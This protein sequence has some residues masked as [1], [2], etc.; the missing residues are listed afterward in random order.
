LNR[1]LLYRNIFIVTFLLVNLKL[2]AQSY[3][4]TY[5]AANSLSNIQVGKYP[6]QEVDIRFLAEHTGYVERIRLFIAR[7]PGYSDGT[8]GQ[9]KISLETDD[10]TILHRPSGNILASYLDLN[11]LINGTHNVVYTFNNPAKLTAGKLYHIHF[12]NPDSNPMNNWVSINFIYSTSGTFDRMPVTKILN[13]AV[14]RKEGL[15]PFKD[16]TDYT[17]LY[18]LFYSDSTQ[19]GQ[20]YHFAGVQTPNDISGNDF[21]VRSN[22]TVSGGDKI[23]TKVWARIKKVSGNEDLIMRLEETDGSLI[24]EVVVPNSEISS[25]M[26]WIS[27][28][29]ISNHK[30]LNGSN[31][32]LTLYTGNSTTYQTFWM[33]NGGLDWVIMFP[34]G[35][36]QYTTTG[37]TKWS[38][39]IWYDAQIFF[40][41]NNETSVPKY[42]NSV[43][44]DANPSQVKITY[45]MTLAEPVPPSTAFTVLVNGLQVFLN[46]I[47][48]V[49]MNV[50]LALA[51]P[52]VPDD[53]ITLSYTKPEINPL[54][55]PYGIEAESLS[56]ELVENQVYKSADQNKMII[57]PNPAQSF[58]KISIKM[59]D[60]D[61][62]YI[63]IMD[64]LGKQVFEYKINAGF[65][66]F[67]IPEQ[68]YNGIYF[69]LLFYNKI[70]CETQQLIISR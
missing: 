24:E 35:E 39:N 70:L 23:V 11:P 67:Q 58:L 41:L 37:G 34:D 8:G 4:G 27:K 40:E 22:F 51:K 45:N 2:L 69:V 46:S 13:L 59:S 16:Q 53:V 12:T 9:L 10:G 61:Q 15:T 65:N 17:P 7:G 20:G 29:F 60:F 63:K 38:S 18:A 57:Y 32:H 54:K 66:E 48:I 21:K 14:L 33:Q 49:G 56:A 64:L 36:Y 28:K 30:L 52:I 3:Y 50:F 43:I 42:L 44:E 19:T 68:F 55:T 25:S 1:F 31:Y 5:Y 47:T 62:A 26:G 6:N